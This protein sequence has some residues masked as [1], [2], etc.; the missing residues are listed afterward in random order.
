MAA[1]RHGTILI[2]GG[3]PAKMK[4][5]MKEAEK[6][7]EQFFNSLSEESRKKIRGLAGDVSK[8]APA[9]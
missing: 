1:P 2:L 9:R 6:N 3:D 8:P 5:M 7:P 4:E